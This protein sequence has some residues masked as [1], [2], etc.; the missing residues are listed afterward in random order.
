MLT[1]VLK[2]DTCNISLLDLRILTMCLIGFAGFLRY[3]ELSK[4]KRS[5]IVFCDNYIKIFI[6]QSKTDLCREGKWV[7]IGST[8]TLCCPVKMIKKYIKQ[9]HIPDSSRKYIFRGMSYF[10]KKK[11][12]K[13]RTA[14]QSLSYTR[15]REFMLEAFK[16]VGLNHK[17]LGTHSLR[18]GGGHR[19]GE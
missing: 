10:S 13:L 1:L 15:T 9:A 16:G 4:L 7:F 19:R 8:G 3:D 5:D 17:K 2:F 18:A 12:H 11:I 6:E 14:D